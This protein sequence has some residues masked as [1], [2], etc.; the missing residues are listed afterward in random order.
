MIEVKI[1]IVP[2]GIREREKQ[3]GYIKLWNDG[4]GSNKTG[5]Y[6]YRI[7]NDRG[8]DIEGGLKGFSREDGVFELLKKVLED[9]T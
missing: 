1:N 3:I 5:N 8:I 2:F 4:T 7:T 9:A 6:G